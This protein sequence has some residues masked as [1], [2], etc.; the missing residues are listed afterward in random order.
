M[1]QNSEHPLKNVTISFSLTL[2]VW[3]NKYFILWSLKRDYT[4]ESIETKQEINF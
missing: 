3:I 1:E 2:Y 4:L